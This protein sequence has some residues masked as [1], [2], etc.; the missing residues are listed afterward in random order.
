MSDCAK[1]F[2]RATF[3]SLDE[4]FINAE[5]E[6]PQFFEIKKDIFN[7]DQDGNITLQKGA[8][9]IPQKFNKK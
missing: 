7:V 6:L 8:D 1:E 2:K 3:T 5:E 9:F 4:L